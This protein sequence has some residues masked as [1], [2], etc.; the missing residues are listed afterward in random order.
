[1]SSGYSH[2]AHAGN[3]ADVHKHWLLSLLLQTLL[4]DPAPLHYLESHAGAG[5]Y[6]RGKSFASGIARLWQQ[7]LTAPSLRQYL[8]QVTQTN[9][10]GELN[11]YPGSPRIAAHTLRKQ[12]QGL[13]VEQDAQV[14]TQLLHHLGTDRRIDIRHGDGLMVVNDKL[15]SKR[16][17]LL[18]IDPP[19]I[20]ARE[21]SQVA[22]W[23]SRYTHRLST[24]HIVLWYPITPQKQH[25]ELLDALAHSLGH[26]LGISVLCSEF[27]LKSRKKAMY[28][29]GVSLLNPP[30]VLAPVIRQAGA[31]LATR[32]DCEARLTTLPGPS[33]R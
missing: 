28:G 6:H 33:P 10:S 30:P 9:P 23:L 25:R 5:H 29:S 26:S 27:R 15:L 3:Y 8:A 2:Q 13:L 1:M 11:T 19:F 21:F 4:N 14:F 16:R 12:D 32:L 31:E 18:L 22:S 24:G 7:P 17:Y 20:R